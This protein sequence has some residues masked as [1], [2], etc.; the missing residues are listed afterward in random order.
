MKSGGEKDWKALIALC[1]TLSETPS[2]RLE[3]A[4]EPILDIDGALWFLALDNALIN[5][6]GYWIRASDYSIYRDPTGRF[7][8][9]PHDANETFQPPMG[10]GMGGGP[11]GP[12]GRGRR[13]G[14]AGKGFAGAIG[15]GNA[16]GQDRKKTG[17][18]GGPGLG[19][20]LDPLVGMDDSRK[21]L[22]SR[23]LAVPGLRD[24]YLE[25]V[26]T[27]AQTWLDW[28]T[29]GP[30]V[31][32]YR[33]LIEKYVEAD[34]R[35]LTSTEAF[36]TVTDDDSRPGRTPSPRGRASL[37]L[38]DFATQRREYLLEAIPGRDQK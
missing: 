29:L 14:P 11:G 12:G 28:K 33:A 15:K 7:H 27:I 38:R 36:R 21:P 18:S 10:P 34:T 4:L 25:H 17:G 1:K 2:D 26:R 23:L 6:D 20:K 9:I 22:R 16:G 24:R 37:S 19:V 31:A 8:V 32:E 5:S 35:K 3:S 13:G 30:I